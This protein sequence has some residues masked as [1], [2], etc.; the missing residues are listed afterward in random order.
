MVRKD[1]VR[2]ESTLSEEEVLKNMEGLDFSMKSKP[3]WKKRCSFAHF[4]YQ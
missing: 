2:F 1:K 4:L 3:D